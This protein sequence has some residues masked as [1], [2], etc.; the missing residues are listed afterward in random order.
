MDSKHADESLTRTCWQPIFLVVKKYKSHT[1]ES[2]PNLGS[3]EP[4]AI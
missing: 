2:A 3:K 1:R 4:R